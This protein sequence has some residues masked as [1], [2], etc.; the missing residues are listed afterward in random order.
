[1][2]FS[3]TNQPKQVH[4]KDQR[5]KVFVYGS[6]LKDFSNHHRLKSQS[7]I[8]LGEGT[9]RANLYTTNWAFP[10]ITLS[11][12]ND[13]KVKGEIYE[14][15]YATLLSLDNLE[16]YNPKRK[17]NFY[18]RKIVTTT[19]SYSMVF[20]NSTKVKVLVYTGNSSH[21]QSFNMQNYRQCNHI[22]DGDWRKAK[23]EYDEEFNLRIKYL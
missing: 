6:L 7:T 14:I 2:K 15:N 13:N 11:N 1:M 23:N 12:N 21:I 20:N 10:F 19:I 8:F 22:I 18:T 9:I 16:G 4:P 5:Y 3:S 17:D